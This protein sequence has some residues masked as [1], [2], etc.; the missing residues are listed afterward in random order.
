MLLDSDMS[1][2]I[3]FRSNLENHHKTVIS[4]FPF[5]CGVGYCITMIW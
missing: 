2:L 3:H 1:A 4:F 5:F